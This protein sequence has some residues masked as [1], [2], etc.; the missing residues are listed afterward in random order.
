MLAA[1]AVNYLSLDREIAN[2]RQSHLHLRPHFTLTLLA[3]A[4]LSQSPRFPSLF[5]LFSRPLTGH[6]AKHSNITKHYNPPAAAAAEWQDEVERK[7]RRGQRHSFGM[8]MRR[9]N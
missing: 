1:W 7:E 9:S 4:S 8:Q 3:S 2:P 6:M 5:P